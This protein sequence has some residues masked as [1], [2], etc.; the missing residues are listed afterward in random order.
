MDGMFFLTTLVIIYLF[1]IGYLGYRGFRGTRTAAD[2]LVAGRQVHPYVMAMSYGATFISTSAIVGFGGVAA[3]YGLSILWLVVLN[4]F[5]GIFLAFVFMGTRTRRMGHRLD[6][7]TFPE[8]LGRRFDSRFIQI[9]S[10]VVIALFM[11]LYTAVVLMGAARFIEVRVGVSYEVALFFFSVI[12]ALYVVMGGLKGVMYT[13]ALQGT[14]MLIG[15]VLILI[16]TLSRLGGIGSAFERLAD[17]APLIPEGLRAKG[18]QGWTAM[19]AFGSEMWWVMV[20]TIIMG[21]GIGVL[22]QPQLAVRFMTVKS[23][24]ELNRAVLIGGIFILLIPGVA[25]LV[26]A[27][28]NILFLE[29]SAHGV[30]SIQ[31]AEGVVGQIIPL[32]ITTQ[33]PSWLFD[34]FMVTLL[35]AGMS[36]VSSQFHAMG[37]A[38]GRDICETLTR[39]TGQH[40][41]FAARLGILLTFLFSVAL[42]YLLVS[43]FSDVGTAIIARGTSI[44]FGLCASTFLPMF[45]GGLFSRRITRPGALAGALVGFSASAFWLLFMHQKE[46][47]SLRICEML[48][49]KVS[50][51]EGART[52]FILWPHVDPLFI[53]FPLAV[54]ATIVISALTQPPGEEHLQRC[55]GGQVSA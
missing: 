36:T 33:M 1:L 14:V 47:A 26:G 12:V 6:A 11:P 49:G 45:I 40:T 48:T 7:H 37:T 27:L 34:L 22:A 4:I 43:V 16:L 28:S 44:F 39:S 29:D 23:S 38:V 42:A 30:I 20:S 53:A 24:R 55:F 32:F 5:V 17:M 2:Y 25:Y 19:P 31:A 54:I 46:S 18:H 13:D 10:G 50:L 9:F 41:I 15:M 8:L 21:V 35:A 52:G 51:V 3:I